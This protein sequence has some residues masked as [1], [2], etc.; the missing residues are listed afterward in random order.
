MAIR[1]IANS[2][3][4]SV[5]LA[6]LLGLCV[7]QT[8]CVYWN[9]MYNAKKHFKEAEKQNN[10]ELGGTK[11][12][13]NRRL[14][15]DA[16]AKAGKVVQKHPKSKY[17]D[18]ALFLIGVS[19]FRIDNYA[20][21]E[22]AFRELLAVHPKSEFVEESQLY[23]ARCRM[24][25]GDAQAAYRTFTDLAST[26]RK[27]EWRAE[28]TFQ[29]G[30]Y[31]SEIG[32]YDSAVAAFQQILDEYPNTDRANDARVLAADQLR[33][34]KRPSEAMDLYTP[35]TT[36][37][38]P[39]VRYP[40]LIGLGGACYEAGLVDSGIAV[41]DAMAE[42]ELY[43]D[44]IGNIRLLLGDGLERRG[45]VNG[46]WRQ[47][48]QVAAALERTRWSAEAY[49]NMAE[50]KQYQQGD[51]ASAKEYYDKVRE[52]YA[53][54]KLSN[55][56]LTRSANISKL[57]Q[58][59]K[60]LGRG[61]LTRGPVGDSTLVY[62]PEDLP[63]YERQS[64]SSP[65]EARPFDFVHSRVRAKHLEDS[66]AALSPAAGSGAGSPSTGDQL[67]F[68]PETP[69]EFKSIWDDPGR[70]GPQTPPEFVVYGKA[71]ATS[72]SETESPAGTAT[73]ADSS[74]LT[75]VFGPPID[76][77]ELVLNLR[78]SELLSNETWEKLLEADSLYGPP[79]PASAYDFGIGPMF[80][81]ETPNEILW[82]QVAEPVIDST[83][84]RE[85][86]ARTAMRKEREAA[87]AEIETAA[88]TQ[89]QLAELYRFDLN[90]PDSA[91]AEYND[92]AERYKG[93]P[94]GA[95]ALLAAADIY[96]SEYDDSTNARQ[97]LLRILAEYPH[98]DYA[99]DAIGRLGWRGTDADTA[100]PMAAYT[101]AEDRYLVD[102]DPEAA[103]DEFRAFIDKYPYSRL[104]PR[105]EYAI[106]ALTDRYFPAEDSSVV[107]A[108]QEIAATYAQ[109]DLAQ[110]A[111]QRLSATVT[112]PKPRV[113]S[114]APK[115]DE[116]LAAATKSANR[117]D[118]TAGDESEDLPLAPRAKVYGQVEFP[119][120]DVG[121]ITRE[122]VVVYKI[123]IDFSGNVADLELIQKSTSPD[124]DAATLRAMRDTK[125]NPDSIAPESLMIW[126][127]YVMRVT[128]PAL[129]PDELDRYNRTGGIPNIPQGQ[130]PVIPPGQP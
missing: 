34:L 27:P 42:D 119:S 109:S 3:L 88:E 84:I 114:A 108:Y 82:T 69:E 56:A 87:F 103:I 126:Y 40:A 66:L 48:E 54:G 120:S 76:S 64:R 30:I 115:P 32:S 2:I 13:A 112:R 26:A 19:Y 78:A 8:G 46:A 124:L 74:G 12:T 4:K 21:S 60:S 1:L 125:F 44:S 47:Y 127:K 52:E 36:H 11:M 73:V 38:E 22:S 101:A 14:Y 86:E 98:L 9:T 89:M 63:R 58:F 43:A 16:I 106:A 10:P 18:D 72:L 100:H 20:K 117:Q 113:V 57:E 23:L 80:G 62:D 122:V 50:I 79:S 28:A 93:T 31:L 130:Q 65:I 59:R 61:E 92:I 111:N 53:S 75:G 110:A 55:E 118:S 41:F 33:K 49:F 116:A 37:K 102:N 6:L 129:S 91:L 95:Q 83:A 24:Q 7:S 121:T 29:R 39:L 104:V 90:Y 15:E 81:P 17:H 70:F 123:L 77:L 71:S 35:L 96:T 99:G 45:D 105:A 85:R 5:T 67:A 94:Y 97:R 68:G 128:P 107:W 51:L 25:S